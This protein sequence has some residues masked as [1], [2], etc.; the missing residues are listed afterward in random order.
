MSGKFGGLGSYLLGPNGKAVQD[1]TLSLTGVAGIGGRGLLMGPADN[2]SNPSLCLSLQPVLPSSL[3]ATTLYANVHS[4][5]ISGRVTFW[6]SDEDLFSDTTISVDLQAT[7]SPSSPQNL[8]WIL[9]NS[10]STNDLY[11][12]SSACSAATSISTYASCSMCGS[13]PL[14]RY[15]PIGDL[16]AKHG[17]LTLLP[18]VIARVVTDVTLPLRG[19]WG[20]LGLNLVFALPNGVPI[21]CAPISLLTQDTNISGVEKLGRYIYIIVLLYICLLISIRR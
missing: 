10:C 17:S 11:N 9:A 13:G 15:C 21:T 6:Q 4:N 14:Q 7:L 3:K 5:E 8:T 2:A 1:Y 20:V 12:P 19:P 18:G 16:T